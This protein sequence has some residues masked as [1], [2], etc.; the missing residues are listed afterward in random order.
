MMMMMI[1]IIDDDVRKHSR[2]AEGCIRL[3]IVSG[4]FDWA[5]G[6]TAIIGLLS[7]IQFDPTIFYFFFLIIFFL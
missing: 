6:V 7:V 2:K 3:T 1:I 5:R 4:E